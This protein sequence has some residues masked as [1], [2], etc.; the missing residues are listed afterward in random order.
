MYLYL[1]R[2]SH[3]NIFDNHL[4]TY[5]TGCP[6][7]VGASMEQRRTLV[8]RIKFCPQCFHPDIVFTKDHLKDCQFSKSG[9]KNAYI[10]TVP[11]CK[12]HIWICLVHRR[13]NK[14]NMERFKADL[15]RKGLNLALTT[16]N[17]A[18]IHRDTDAYNYAVKK[19]KNYEKKKKVRNRV[20][21][22]PVPE[23]EP[24]F[25]FHAAQGKSKPV[26]VFYDSG[27][28]HAIFQADIP[29]NQLKAQLTAKGPFTIGG[30][31]GLTTVALDEWL[32]QI[33]RTDGRN[34]LVQGLTVPQVTSEFP[35][36][37]LQS[38]VEE[39]KGADTANQSLQNCKVP[40]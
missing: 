14:E 31:G 4:S 35:M 30:V 32:V 27:C 8:E 34:Q 40:P 3:P 21:M 38:A 28:S 1:S 36:I 26:N 19:M 5:P 6:Q 9:R 25:L 39:I 13:D 10:C 37:S 22:V 2:G 7:F 12:T 18:G 20:E 33:P 16:L 17:F 15:R 29:F 24:L 23:G 11:S